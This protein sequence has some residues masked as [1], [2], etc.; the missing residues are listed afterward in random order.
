LPALLAIET[1]DWAR[2]A[3]LQPTASAA[4]HSQGITLLTHA[5]AAAHRGDVAAADIAEQAY[6][7]LLAREPIVRPG[8]GL[9]TLRQEIQAWDQVA[10]GNTDAA[11]A[12]LKPVTDRQREVGKGEVELPAGEMIAAMLLMAGKAT[13]ALQAYQSSLFSDPNR[14]NALLGAGRAAELSGQGRLSRQYYRAALASCSGA[15]AT[16]SPRLQHARDVLKRTSD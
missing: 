4:T 14:L 6:S 16:S 8:G 13:Q 12:L 1:Q 11:L 3:V 2:A 15:N 9:D 5:I 7:V 10:H